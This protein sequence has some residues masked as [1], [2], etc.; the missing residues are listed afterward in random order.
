MV[1]AAIDGQQS[2]KKRKN[3]YKSN[4]GAFVL[5][6]LEEFASNAEHA[7]DVAITDEALR[8]LR[9]R[10]IECCVAGLPQPVVQQSTGSRTRNVRD[11]EL[12]HVRG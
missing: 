6:M 5:A 8:D 10:G 3:V 4:N 1:L 7:N 12:V 2:G 9:L 11:F